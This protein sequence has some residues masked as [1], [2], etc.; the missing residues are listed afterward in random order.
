MPF[1]DICLLR[2]GPQDLPASAFLLYLTLIAHAVSGFLL[3]VGSHPPGTAAMA[4]VTDTALLALLTLSLLY[5][6]GQGARV[7]QTLSALAGSDTLIGLLALAPTYWLAKAQAGNNDRTVPDV[8][9]LLLIV[10]SLVVMGHVIRHALSTHLFVGVV[11]A[12]VFYGMVWS[13]N[14]ALFP[15]P[16]PD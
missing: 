7:R 8:L 6:N 14:Q 5:V 9:L 16:L 12:V 1:T 15:L 3:T 11:I 10:W 2:R 4:A 13:V